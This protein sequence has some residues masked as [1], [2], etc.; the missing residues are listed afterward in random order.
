M[1]PRSR[2]TAPGSPDPTCHNFRR[3]D[4]RLAFFRSAKVGIGARCGQFVDQAL[5]CH[6]ACD[7]LLIRPL[8]TG[9]EFRDRAGTPEQVALRKSHAGSANDFELSLGLNSFG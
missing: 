4:W 2:T 3:E 6:L 9:V 1:R 5:G 8:K 7:F